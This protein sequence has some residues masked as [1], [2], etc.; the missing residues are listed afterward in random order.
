VVIAAGLP[1]EGAAGNFQV[2]EAVTVANQVLPAVAV[3]IAI[4][5]TFAQANSSTASLIL[6]AALV[7]FRN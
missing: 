3:T 7:R 2:A 1:L 4:M 6:E 5:P